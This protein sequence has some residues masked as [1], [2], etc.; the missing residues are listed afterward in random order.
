M[1][2]LRAQYRRLIN[3]TLPKR[4]THPV[5]YNHC[6]ARI[7]LDW[8]FQD[9]WYHHLQRNKP[10]VHQLSEQ[11]LHTAIERMQAWLHDQQLLIADNKASLHYRKRR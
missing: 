6:F 1:N 9:C 2:G 5:Q 3:H 7:I 4:F 10:A 11:Q 8:L